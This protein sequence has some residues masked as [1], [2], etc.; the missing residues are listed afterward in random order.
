MIEK[1]PTKMGRVGEGHKRV[2]DEV[3]EG[4]LRSESLPKHDEAKRGLGRAEEGRE[5]GEQ[6]G[7]CQNFQRAG[8][9][10]L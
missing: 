5:E 7:W 8:T 4:T 10:A 2:E 6:Q 9:F 3:I 1:W